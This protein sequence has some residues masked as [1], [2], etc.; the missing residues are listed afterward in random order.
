LGL[1]QGRGQPARHRTLGWVRQRER[2]L[3]VAAQGSRHWGPLL[4]P[5]RLGGHRTSGGGGRGWGTRQGNGL[6]KVPLHHA[7]ML[8]APRPHHTLQMFFSQTNKSR[9]RGVWDRAACKR[10]WACWEQTRTLRLMREHGTSDAAVL[11]L[12]PIVHQVDAVH[13][14]EGLPD[15]GLRI[16]CRAWGRGECGVVLYTTTNTPL[17]T[18]H[19]LSSHPHQQRDLQKRLPRSQPRSA[20]KS[21]LCR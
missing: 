16:G 15:F 14:N 4:P 2:A 8:P 18:Q 21:N 11:Q 7:P 13:C 17:C 10:E 9:K 1:A 20:Q 3:G 6:V 12:P 19:Q 5:G